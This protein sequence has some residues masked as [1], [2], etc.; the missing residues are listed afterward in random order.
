MEKDPPT[1]AKSLSAMNYYNSITQ[2]KTIVELKDLRPSTQK[3]YFDAIVRLAK[4]YQTDPIFLTEDQIRDYFLFLRRSNFSYGFMNIAKA[5]LQCFYIE[6]VRVQNWSVFQQLRIARPQIL[7]VV[8]SAEEVGKLLKAVNEPR[9]RVCL[10]LIHQCGLRISEAVNLECSD[11]KARG[12]FPHLHIRNGKGAKDRLVP[13]SPLMVVE[14]REWWK[15][16]GHRRFLFPSAS[17]GRRTSPQDWKR[18]ARPMNAASLQN[19]FRIAR[20]LS[21]I[22]PQATVHTL[23]HSFATGLLERGVSLVQISKYLGH[24]SLNTTLIYTHL[25]DASEAKTQQALDALYQALGS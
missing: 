23:R 7:P 1:R 18:A 10:K 21:G 14:L 5:S 15:N 24:K 25:T 3:A 6:H 19:V 9:F 11:I 8:C 12:S 22:N 20:T 2:F 13:I 17:R 4:H 16:H